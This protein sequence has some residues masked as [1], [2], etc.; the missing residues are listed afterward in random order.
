MDSS[1][2]M[3]TFSQILELRKMVKDSYAA[4]GKLFERLKVVP[5][6]VMTCTVGGFAYSRASSRYPV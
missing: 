3:T 4:K 5:A 2:Q 6:D 1:K